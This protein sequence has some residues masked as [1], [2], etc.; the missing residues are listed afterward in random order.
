MRVNTKK[1][2]LKMLA[3]N[4]DIIVYKCNNTVGL[5]A[6]DVKTNS[7]LTAFYSGKHNSSAVEPLVVNPSMVIRTL[8]DKLTPIELLIIKHYL[9]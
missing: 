6:H 9:R 3:D 2:S 7:D 8:K 4:M 5:T 1:S